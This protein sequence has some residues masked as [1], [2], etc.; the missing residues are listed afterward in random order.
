MISIFCCLP[1]EEQ[2]VRPCAQHD[3]DG[4]GIFLL[5]LACQPEGDVEHHD[6]AAENKD[7][8]GGAEG[9]ALDVNLPLE[10]RGL[11]RGLDQVEDGPNDQDDLGDY[12]DLGHRGV[13]RV[14]EAHVVGVDLGLG[15]LQT[16]PAKQI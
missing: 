5:G 16:A 6:G 1:A 13:V 8:P 9:H 11:L 7:N 12:P 10:E 4:H 2:E 3:S 15:T 14:P